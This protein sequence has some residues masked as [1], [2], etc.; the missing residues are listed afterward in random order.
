LLLSML[1]LLYLSDKGL[2]SRLSYVAC[3]FAL[4]YAEPVPE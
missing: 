4:F 2:S 3:Y 1:Y